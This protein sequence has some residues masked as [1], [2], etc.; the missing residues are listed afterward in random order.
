MSLIQPSFDPLPDPAAVVLGPNVRFTVLTSRLIRMESS[1]TSLFE[2]HP[3]QAFWFRRQPV[4]AFEARADPQRIEIETEHLRLS[5]R[6]EPEALLEVFQ[7]SNLRVEVKSTGAIWRPGDSYRQAGNLWGT[8]RTLDD[9]G[10]KIRLEP[11][12][13][14]RQGWALVDDSRSLVFDQDNWLALREAPTNQDWYFFGY[15]HDYAA[16]LA[17]FNRVS[18]QTPMIPRWALGNWWSRYWA[19][20]AN[21]LLSLMDEFREHAVPLSVCIVDMDW[22]LTETGN[23]STGWTG[24]TW[25]QALFADP[26]AFIQSMH[27]LGLKVALNLHPAEGVHPHEASYT[28]LAEYLEKDAAAGRPI[29]FQAANPRFMQGYFE[30]LHHP[31]EAQ[32][33]DF[34]WLDWQQGTPA[35]LAGLDPLW[36]LNHLHFYDHA[37]GGRTRPFIFSRWGGLGNHRYP[38]GFSGDTVVGWEALDF[39]PA[40]TAAAANVGYGWW[41]HDIGGHMGGI[42]DDELYIRWVQFGV[43]SPILRLH[44]TKNPYHERRPWGRGHLAD[45]IASQAMRLRHALIPYLYTMAWRN[46]TQSL[47]L[48]THL[49]YSHPENEEAYACPRQYWFG[50]QLIAAP[51]TRPAEP[52]LGLARQVVW[53][54]PGQ[55]FNF[56]TGEPMP[57][58]WQT[59]YG[60][61]EDIPV[62]APAGA[63]VPMAPQAGWGPPGTPSALHLYVFPGVSQRFELYED[64]GETIDYLSGRYALTP[65]TQEWQT[66][67]LRFSILPVLGDASVT[68]AQRAYY[69][70]LRGLGQP[71]RIQAS[72]N[73][74]PVAVQ[75]AC[76]PHTDTL[77][78]D[79][80]M[81]GPTDELVITVEAGESG[82]LIERRDRSL[83]TLRKCLNAFRLDSWVKARIEAAWPAIRSGQVSLSSFPALDEAQRAALENVHQRYA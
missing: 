10:G 57:S 76:N 32:G 50:S 59:V 27:D 39:Q 82:D 8:A 26:P 7:A 19:Y 65:F 79:P 58:G 3:S 70:H 66:G 52:S 81:L 42:E 43:F 67:Q 21:D 28:A 22:H 78:F 71:G 73:G 63:I 18:G 15:G 51:F 23:L 64:D 53:M 44:S 74:Q 1:P 77:S 62:F 46:H 45:H 75:T 37:R 25:N 24:Y 20:S 35:S 17:D 54:P 55:W 13:I 12:L 5:Y 83:D 41:S 33:V 69:I 11:G 72:L 30:L 49:Y 29:P 14:A 38:I 34:W 60:G 48:I 56:F 6:I 80:L 36:W 68:A 2:D 47:P 61:P 4:P 9:T 16:C 31:L 40:F